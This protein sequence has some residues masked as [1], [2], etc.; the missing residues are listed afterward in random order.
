MR[1]SPMVVRHLAVAKMEGRAN[2]IRTAVYTLEQRAKELEAM[3][4]AE[5]E[6]VMVK[7][8]HMESASELRAQA[9][10]IGAL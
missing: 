2:A 6:R 4:E 1:A 8:A 7:A 10:V 9:K 5:L 3:A